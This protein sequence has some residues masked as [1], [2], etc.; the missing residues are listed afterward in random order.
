MM[1]EKIHFIEESY[2]EDCQNTLSTVFVCKKNTL[3]I[4][5]SLHIWKGKQINQNYTS[6]ICKYI[7]TFTS[8]SIQTKH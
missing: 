3:F 5:V 6:D 7:W 8:S 1:L 4:K 2:P